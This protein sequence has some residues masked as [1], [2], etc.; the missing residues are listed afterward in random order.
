[1]FAF[2]R[3]EPA[4]FG[5]AVT[6][7]LALALAFGLHVNDVQ[8]GAIQGIVTAFL[9]LVVAYGVRANVTP[10]AVSPVSTPAPTVPPAA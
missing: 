2:I 8:Q 5:G 4:L 3:R 1:M 6:A 10:T 7:L 9:A